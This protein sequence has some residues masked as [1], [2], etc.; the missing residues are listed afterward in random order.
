MWL[1]CHWISPLRFIQ[2]DFI[3]IA[4]PFPLAIR[5]AVDAHQVAVARRAEDLDHSTDLAKER[6]KRPPPLPNDD[7]IADGRLTLC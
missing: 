5:V 6:G 3:V 1:L 2:H 7:S 4:K